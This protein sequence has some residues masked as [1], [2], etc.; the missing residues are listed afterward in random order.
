MKTNFTFLF[1]VGCLCMSVF[2]CSKDVLDE[3]AEMTET[4]LEVGTPQINIVGSDKDRVF[5]NSSEDFQD[6]LNDNILMRTK[7]EELDTA[8]IDWEDYIRTAYGCVYKSMEHTD[9]GY[10]TSQK[11]KTEAIAMYPDGNRYVSSNCIADIYKLTYRVPVD[12][13]DKFY[14]DDGSDCGYIDNPVRGGWLYSAKRGYVQNFDGDNYAVLTTH[15]VHLSNGKWFPCKPE[16]VKWHYW[17]HQ[18]YCP[19]F[20]PVLS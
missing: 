5:F 3:T 6:Y 16:E 19:P 4:L 14:S 18:W 9:L 15:I 20:P 13:R 2:S 7:S 10:T 17:K 11:I 1:A 12:G 8:G